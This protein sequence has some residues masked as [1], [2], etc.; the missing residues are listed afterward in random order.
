MLKLNYGNRTKDYKRTLDNNKGSGERQSASR[1][2]LIILDNNDD[3]DKAR[4]GVRPKTLPVKS[5]SSVLK[6]DTSLHNSLLTSKLASLPAESI[7][8]SSLCDRSHETNEKDVEDDEHP[9]LAKRAEAALS[10]CPGVILVHR[11]HSHTPPSTARRDIDDTQYQADYGILSKSPAPAESTPVAEYQEWCFQGFLKRT[12]I[13]NET[14]YNLEFQLSHVPEHL[15]LLIFSVALGMR[16]NRE[17]TAE[18]EMILKTKE[19]GCSWEEIH[20]TLPHQ[21]LGSIFYF[22]TLR[23]FKCAKPSDSILTPNGL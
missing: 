14:T 11:S 8:T 19:E 10:T 12:K 21:I 23:N 6:V 9:R 7:N 16:S 15:H 18:N 5:I 2:R 3:I 1:D 13:G 17:T 4:V 22:K 20:T